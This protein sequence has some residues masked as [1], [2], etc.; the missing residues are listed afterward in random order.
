MRIK[1]AV[2]LTTFTCL[3]SLCL[4]TPA[5]A[6]TFFMDGKLEISGFVKETAYI[7]TGMSD[8]EKIYHDSNLDYLQT[9]LLFETLYTVKEDGD[10]TI[11]LFGGVKW[12]WQKAHYFDQDYRRSIPHR[13]RKDYTHPRSF[14]EDILTEAYIDIIK[15]PWEVRIGKQIC[16]WGQLNMS[17]VADVVNPLDIRRGFPGENPWEDIK[18]GLWMIR[19]FYESELPGNLLFETIFNPGDFQNMEI[20]L[21]GTHKGTK[22]HG[23]RWFE[24]DEQKFGVYHWQ[25]EKWTR[26]APGWNLK[27]NWELGFRVRGNTFGFDWTLLY[28]NARDD[29]PIAHPDRIGDFTTPFIFSGILTAA[30]GKWVPPPDWSSSRKVYYYKRYQTVGGTTQVYSHRLWDTVW[31]TEWFY[32]I[33]RPL[34]KA[35]NGDSREIYGWTRRNIFGAALQC[36]KAL[37]I[38]WFT[39]SNI[40]TDRMLDISLTYY[41]EKVQNHD[42]DLVLSDRD[43]AWTNSTTDALILF[44]KQDMFNSRIIFVLNARYFLRTG[45]WM[46]IPSMSYVF[47]GNHWRFD[48]GYVA[49][50]G[51]KRR[52]VKSSATMDKITI[53]LRYVF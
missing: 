28:W 26:D 30:T 17:R 12:W 34:N 19:V 31:R 47:P 6:S 18:Q 3:M 37:Y 49:E 16:I 45:K 48:M 9:S 7:R 52:F 53:R 4:N 25:R 14:N 21:E 41:W 15:G 2:I 23:V 44:M 29:T 33:N 10:L 5:H 22:P 38:P 1:S 13:D 50:G 36:N 32:E 51:P 24:P 40:A 46:V 11:R 43:H 27:D 39:K 8:R 35:V 42:H 20:V